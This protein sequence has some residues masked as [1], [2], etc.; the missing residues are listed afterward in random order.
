MAKLEP[1]EDFIREKIER[2]QWT[3]RCLYEYFCRQCPGGRGFSIR[4]IER[5]CH[6]QNIH[7]T[8][9]LSDLALDNCVSEA[10]AKVKY[11]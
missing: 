10:I 4:S 11:F 5:F 6:T 7:R 3:H 1:F 8:A 9:R 2:E